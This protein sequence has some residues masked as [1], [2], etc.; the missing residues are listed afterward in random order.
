MEQ[1]GAPVIIIDASNVCRDA[2][3]APRGQV[4]AWARLE[5]L[6]AE[7]KRS[8]EV[9]FSSVYVVA[10]RSLHYSLDRDGQQALRRLERDGKAEQR[11]FADERIVELAFSSTSQLQGALIATHDFFDDFRRTYPEIQSSPARAVGWRANDRGAPTPYLREFGDRTHQRVSRKEE[12]GELAERRLRRQDVQQRAA[13]TYFRCVN[14]ASCLVA[15]LWPERL[16]ELPRYDEAGDTFVCPSCGSALEHG[17]RRAAAVQVIVYLSDQERA[18]L[19]LEEGVDLDIGRVDAKGCIGLERHVAAEHVAAVSRRH[20][21]LELRG[22]EVTITDLQSKNG[23]SLRQRRAERDELR[24]LRPGAPER[25]GLRDAVVLPGGITLERSG[26]RHPMVGQ[27]RPE[28]GVTSPGA[29][30]T[31]LAK[32]QDRW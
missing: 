26:R 31:T 3:L 23:T 8:G 27:R 11:R 10:D 4:A 19:L 32:P 9:H 22:S 30:A 15:K 18:R 17:G 6:I 16:E 20:L 13:A 24:R 28:H 29:A 14:T 7:L 21:H 25:W 12:E 1:P 5:A 2:D